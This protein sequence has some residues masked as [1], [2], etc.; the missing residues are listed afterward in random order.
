MY[1]YFRGHNVLDNKTELQK[2]M[3]KRNFKAKD[4]ER[5][6]SEETE[7]TPF[8]KMLEERAK[9]LEQVQID[10]NNVLMNYRNNT[11]SNILMIKSKKHFIQ[12]CFRLNPDRKEV[13]VVTQATIVETVVRSQK[14]R[15]KGFEQV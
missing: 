5:K 4:K 12:Y 9:R 8:Q 2:A 10:Q 6:V 7:K 11:F 1:L 3:E 13:V 14:T 15:F